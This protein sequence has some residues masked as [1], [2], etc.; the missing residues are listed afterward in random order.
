MVSLRHFSRYSSQVIHLF[1]SLPLLCSINS[2]AVALVIPGSFPD[3]KRALPPTVTTALI[4]TVSALGQVKKPT[5]THKTFA[6]NNRCKAGFLPF[7]AIS[8][9]ICAHSKLLEFSN[10]QQ[11]PKLKAVF[12]I[13][14]FEV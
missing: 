13:G 14:C 1:T 8:K 6:V 11:K 2:L 5:L 4:D 7:Y 10:T 12:L 9:T 3:I